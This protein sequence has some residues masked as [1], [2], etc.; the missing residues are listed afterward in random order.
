MKTFLPPCTA[1][2]L[3]AIFLPLSAAPSTGQNAMQ[4]DEMEKRLQLLENSL[5]R[6][7]EGTLRE[8][9]ETLFRHLERKISGQVE[10]AALA[11][12]RQE[13]RLT[14]LEN[15]LKQLQE[16]GKSADAERRKKFSAF[17]AAEA[18]KVKA[19]SDRYTSLISSGFTAL[20]VL[21]PIV[22]AIP[23]LLGYLGRRSFD[24]EAES[25]LVEMDQKLA[26][27]ETLVVKGHQHE[28]ELKQLLEKNKP[29]QE[30]EEFPADITQSAQKAVKKNVGVEALRGRA[31]L[32]QNAKDWRRACLYWEDVIKEDPS[33]K[34]ARFFLAHCRI[35]L[36]SWGDVSPEQR[37]LLWK[38]AEDFYREALTG[39]PT[40]QQPNVLIAYAVL[41]REQAKFADAN[42]RQQ[43]YTEAE[44]FLRRSG[45]REDMHILSLRAS[46]KRELAALQSDTVKR[47]ELYKEAEQ[48]LLQARELAPQE[49]NIIVLLATLKLQQVDKQSNPVE[50]IRLMKESEQLLLQ[51][52]KLAPQDAT[53][54]AVLAELKAQQ[55]DEQSNP[56]ERVRLREEAEQLLSQA[57]K[58]APQDAKSCIMLAGLKAQ[59]ADE[60]SNPVERVRLRKEAEQLLLK[61][62]TLAPQNAKIYAA[63][64]E[65]K[66][67]QAA[68]KSKPKANARLYEE[69]EQLLFKAMTLVP[70]DATSYTVL[71]QLKRQQAAGQSNP[72]ERV[73]LREEAEQL[74]AQAMKL[75][76]QEAASYVVLAQ[77]K[78]QQ[79]NEQSKPEERARLRKKA[80]KVFLQA[81][82]FDPK[83][84]DILVMLAALKIEQ[85]RDAAPEER[86]GLLAAAET[87][88]AELLPQDSAKG[89]YNR[90]CIAALRGQHE[91]ALELLEECRKTGTLP[92]R[93]HLEKDKDMDSLRGLDAFKEFL[94]QAYPTEDTRQPDNAA[95][96]N[97]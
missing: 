17:A 70:Q 31:V 47:A 72:K 42:S 64:A 25:K 2:L 48:L 24:K 43:L 49:V 74:L 63:L 27:M 35:L 94:E 59:Q 79:A 95:K 62:G 21:T 97:E 87:Y 7:V 23:M 53:S 52:M 77:L 67:Q 55:A 40:A 68:G 58:L 82:E 75:A 39:P 3:L 11:T 69:A 89:L 57:M 92:P 46:I 15:E 93:E 65:L 14:E 19:A 28:Q 36:G 34:E 86:D 41:K 88:L 71:A 56:V 5:S 44:D 91:R 73:R 9:M 6:Q 8:E 10:D 16:E 81:K 33:D 37:T 32:A 12:V 51:A 76:P 45:V 20:G 85:A 18:D 38:Q 54:Y 1:I 26:E 84:A 29:P 61:A 50:K 30:Q 13:R 90:A 60:Q 4:R 80:E 78:A 83:E 22:L 96:E 66:L